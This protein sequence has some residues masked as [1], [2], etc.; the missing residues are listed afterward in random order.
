MCEEV[1]GLFDGAANGSESTAVLAGMTGWP[2]VLVV[3]V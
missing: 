1:M 3:D 2:V